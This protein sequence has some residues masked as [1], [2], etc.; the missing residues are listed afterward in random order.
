MVYIYL[1]PCGTNEIFRDGGEALLNLIHNL[2]IK[3]GR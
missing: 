1:T 3:K 2:Q